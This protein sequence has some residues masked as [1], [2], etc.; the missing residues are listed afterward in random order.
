M[1]YSSWH[2]TSYLCN[3]SVGKIGGVL[4]S[5]TNFHFSSTE[6]NS[7]FCAHTVRI[8]QDSFF[9]HS[10]S[11]H[12]LWAK[13]ANVCKCKHWQCWRVQHSGSPNSG[14][15]SGESFWDF[16]PTRDSHRKLLH[17]TSVMKISHNH[18]CSCLNNCGPVQSDIRAIAWQSPWRSHQEM[19]FSLKPSWKKAL[20]R[21]KSK[22]CVTDRTMKGQQHS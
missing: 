16:A 4:S 2:L 8:C 17:L 21:L 5:N 15:G 1:I 7:L 11:K 10:E 12:L 9:T 3:F 20:M 19:N 6:Q 18:G 13:W 14:F 22:V